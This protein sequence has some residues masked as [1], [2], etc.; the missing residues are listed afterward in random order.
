MELSNQELTDE[1]KKD[2]LIEKLLTSLRKER[3]ET[4]QVERRLTSELFTLWNRNEEKQKKMR[5]RR[6][7]I[8]D[9]GTTSSRKK[10]KEKLISDYPLAILNDLIARFVDYVDN[11]KDMTTITNT[12]KTENGWLDYFKAGIEVFRLIN[13][14]LK[15]LLIKDVSW[16][17]EEDP[18]NYTQVYEKMSRLEKIN[19]ILDDCQVTE[20]DLTTSDFEVCKHGFQE[21]AKDLNKLLDDMVRWE[22]KLQHEIK[23]YN[24]EL[25]VQS[26][27]IESHCGPGHR[28]IEEENHENLLQDDNQPNDRKL[29]NNQK[30]E[31]YLHP[32]HPPLSSKRANLEGRKRKDR[33][34]ALD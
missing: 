23:D 17:K 8:K 16:M 12:Q 15:K 29:I 30:V 5:D 18:E 3:M 33:E 14:N 9:E 13:T 2:E 19:E 31:Q 32:S 21:C 27:V 24:A 11:M 28:N 22:G 25:F 34:A 4:F 20:S 1:H 7:V 10:G 26:D 6:L